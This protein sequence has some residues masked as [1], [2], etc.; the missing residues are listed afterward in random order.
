MGV[1]C[2]SARH[3]EPNLWLHLCGAAAAASYSLVISILLQCSALIRLPRLFAAGKYK[4]C[5]PDMYLRFLWRK[6]CEKLQF[7]RGRGRRERKG[8]RGS[9]TVANAN[10]KGTSW[11]T[12]LMTKVMFR[13]AGA[14][15]TLPAGRIRNKMSSSPLPRTP[16]PPRRGQL[17]F[18]AWCRVIYAFGLGIHTGLGTFG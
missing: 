15:I 13:G 3:S 2:P 9:E 18:R 10:K 6:V 8:K 17:Y 16:P 1:L 14:E 5:S 12:G 7:G 4:L 11:S